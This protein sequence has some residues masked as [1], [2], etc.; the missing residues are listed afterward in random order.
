VRLF[1]NVDHFI[2]MIR[3]ENMRIGNKFCEFI[4][5][6]VIMHKNNARDLPTRS[7]RKFQRALPYAESF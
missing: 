1:R 5:E 2:P 7:S 6:I 3:I 4:C